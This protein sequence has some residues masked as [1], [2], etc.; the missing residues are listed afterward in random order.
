M[1]GVE[2]AVQAFDTKEEAQVAA[3][4]MAGTL[5]GLGQTDRYGV[6]VRYTVRV[7]WT[8]LLK[9]RRPELGETQ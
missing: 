5:E 8:V 1:E 2:S 4:R 9:D 7:G 3:D 6:A